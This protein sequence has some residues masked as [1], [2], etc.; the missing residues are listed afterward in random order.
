MNTKGLNNPARNSF[1][2][3]SGKDADSVGIG[4]GDTFRISFHYSVGAS[5]L[6]FIRKMAF[7]D[8]GYQPSAFSFQQNLFKTL[9]YLTADR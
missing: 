7:S 9:N 5:D 2:E 6:V 1:V 8:P 3:I 4:E